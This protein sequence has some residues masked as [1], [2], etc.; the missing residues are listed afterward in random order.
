MSGGKAISAGPLSQ[1]FENTA[2]LPAAAITAK[3]SVV[4]CVRMSAARRERLRRAAKSRNLSAY[5]RSRLFDSTHANGQPMPPKDTIA[6][7]LG[8]LGQSGLAANL[9]VVAQAARTGTLEVGPDLTE[10]L[11][12]ACADIAAMRRDLIRALGIKPESAS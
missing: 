1:N 8:E 2:L 11:N 5:I 9:Q 6:R 10:N 7:I 12:K 4:V 3:T